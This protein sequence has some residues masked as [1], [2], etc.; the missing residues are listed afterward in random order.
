MAG[1]MMRGISGK[2]GVGMAAPGRPSPAPMPI[3]PPTGAPKAAMQSVR[4]PK[5]MAIQVG[6][7]KIKKGF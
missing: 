4:P 6:S 5:N 3:A 1:K 7:P 2:K